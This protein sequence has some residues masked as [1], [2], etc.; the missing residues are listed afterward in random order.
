[1]RGRLQW[2]G[3]LL[4]FNT[5][6]GSVGSS[7][8]R[9]AGT[10]NSPGCGGLVQIVKVQTPLDTSD[11]ARGGIGPMTP[12]TL[13]LSSDP[14]SSPRL[15]REIDEDEAGHTYLTRLAIRHRSS[16]FLSVSHNI[17]DAPLL[18]FFST[19]VVRTFLAPCLVHAA[20]RSFLISHH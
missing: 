13:L 11:D 12:T 10:G 16:V 4:G 15:L 7:V 5:P 6:I 2:G 1:V 3:R 19:S 18:L 8:G 9:D 17:V 20:A 14:A